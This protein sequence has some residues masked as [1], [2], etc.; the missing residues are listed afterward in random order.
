M[1]LSGPNVGE[2]ISSCRP[3]NGSLLASVLSILGMSC[4]HFLK[5]I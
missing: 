4:I 2:A 3:N 5:N 1:E